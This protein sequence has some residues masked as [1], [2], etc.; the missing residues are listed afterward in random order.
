MCDE[1]PEA[2]LLEQMLALR[3]AGKTD[4]QIME[5]MA[6]QELAGTGIELPDDVPPMLPR[7]GQAEWGEWKQ[8]DTTINLELNV[9]D[10]VKAKAVTCEVQVGFLDVRL[11]DEP[12]LSGRLGH[13][14]YSDVEW[15]LDTRAD[16]QRILCIELQKRKATI[17][18]LYAEAL[19]TSLRVGGYETG[20]PGLVSGVYIEAKSPGPSIEQYDGQYGSYDGTV[21][22]QRGKAKPKG[23][24]DVGPLP[25]L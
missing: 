22:D 13:S 5:H 16:G 15:T 10:D 21:P 3:R 7:A 18:M 12:V 8:S 1:I 6:A 24:D 17:D 20:A 11:R 14:C 2:A 19:F 4:A 23:T 25:L 9:D